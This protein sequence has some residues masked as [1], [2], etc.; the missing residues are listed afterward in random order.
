MEHDGDGVGRSGSGDYWSVRL[1]HSK[2]KQKKNVAYSYLMTGS[3]FRVDSYLH[4][5][6]HKIDRTYLSAC[7]EEY[8]DRHSHEES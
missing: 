4:P 7:S 6:G 5:V 8:T 1:K 3:W 2:L